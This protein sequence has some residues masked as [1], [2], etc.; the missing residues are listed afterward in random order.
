[1][2]LHVRHINTKPL[3][4]RNH[5]R[6]RIYEW[7]AKLGMKFPNWLHFPKFSLGLPS[8]ICAHQQI[9]GL[10]A[11]SCRQNAASTERWS[12]TAALLLTVQDEGFYCI[13]IVYLDNRIRLVTS[14]CQW[15][16]RMGERG[17]MGGEI[18][19]GEAIYKECR[20]SGS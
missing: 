2:G 15:E 20:M 1:M 4:V 3:I 13:K 5:T 19:R 7:H 6:S 10:C 14:D 9:I 16:G 8:A 11:G 17:A 18:V 12:F